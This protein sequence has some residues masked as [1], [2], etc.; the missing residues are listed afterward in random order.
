MERDPNDKLGTLIDES[1][2]ATSKA[3]W[4]VKDEENYIKTMNS[5]PIIISEVYETSEG[6]PEQ[7]RYLAQLN[8]LATALRKQ[9]NLIVVLEQ[10]IYEL[11]KKESN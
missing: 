11:G 6:A 5:G 10:C 4:A 8:I 9:H 1:E 7:R 2:K 3:E